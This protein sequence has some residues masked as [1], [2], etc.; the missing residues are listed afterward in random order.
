MALAGLTQALKGTP[1]S[2]QTL[3]EERRPWRDWASASWST[4]SWGSERLCPLCLPLAAP[5][6]W[7]VQGLA[8]LGPLLLCLP[9][10]RPPTGHCV[11]LPT[12]GPP[13]TLLIAV[14][15]TVIVTITV[16]QT[17]DAVAV[18][19][20]KLV[21]LTLPGGCGHRTVRLL[22]AVGSGAWKPDLKPS[23]AVK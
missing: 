9:M 4:V 8:V 20:G 10:A 23:G 6:I 21:L 17:P 3:R 18:L 5:D 7:A 13:T 1:E 11:C 22:Q 15:T 2:V 16:P 14:V 19:A 12:L